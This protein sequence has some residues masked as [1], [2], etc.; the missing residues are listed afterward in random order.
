MGRTGAVDEGSG[1]TMEERV[2]TLHPG[3][4]RHDVRVEAEAYDAV[5]DAILTA[6]T[7]RG[8]LSFAELLLEVQDRVEIPL[9]RPILWI[10]TTVKL[11]ME[12]RGLIERIP[13]TKLQLLRLAQPAHTGTSSRSSR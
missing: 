13:G 5:Q 2:V 6:I 12:A 8:S 10:V 3:G 11:D 9:P 1:E 4:S 7:A